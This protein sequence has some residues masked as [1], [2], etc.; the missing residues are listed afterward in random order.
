MKWL[1]G[2]LSP[3]RSYILAGI[4]VLAVA[5]IGTTVMSYFQIKAQNKTIEAQSA[6]VDTLTATNKG[7]VVWAEKETKLRALQQENVLLLQDKL[8]LLQEQAVV[9]HKQLKDL[10]ASNAEVKAFMAQRLPDDLRVLL[11]RK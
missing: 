9:N 11:N 1:L 10:E 7:W 5:G 8:A 6:Q 4:G 3:F 2:I